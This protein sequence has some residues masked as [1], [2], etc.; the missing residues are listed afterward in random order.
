MKNNYLF[1]S[2]RL[3]FRNWKNEDL[4]EFAAINL[5]EVVME[6]FPKLL[7]KTETADFIKKLK[8]CYIQNGFTYY[9]TE[10]LK[11]KEFIG[12]IGFG[13]QNYKSPFTPA[14]DIGWR[15][16]KNVWGIG[17]ATEGA[18]K[19]L[20]VAFQ[21]LNLIKIISVCT[22][23]NLKSERVMQKIGMHKIGEFNHPMLKVYPNLERCV[24][25]G[26][27]KKPT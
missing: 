22:K 20:D 18:K 1:T 17:F 12:F 14:I 8:D 15:L 7:S 21:K 26:I 13:F 11:T 24:C 27:E 23:N 16:N 5:D 10:I 6:Y 19:C 9:A 2:E 3:G 25:Y 4:T